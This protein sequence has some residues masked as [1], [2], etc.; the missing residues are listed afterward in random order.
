MTTLHLMVGLPCSGKTT[1]ARRLAE[2]CGALLLTP[3]VWHLR[4][5]GQDGQH[6]EHDR[7]HSEIESI[8]WDVARRVLALGCDVILDFG[9]WAREERDDFRKRAEKLGVNFQLH[10]I[11]ASPDELFRRLAIRNQSGSADT[12][13]IA[14]EQMGDYIQI[15]QPPAPDELEG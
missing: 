13:V 4:L 12:F 2:E 1:K 8:M 7:R 5:H 11:E 9:F 3:D 14:I 6:A 15:F 10:Y